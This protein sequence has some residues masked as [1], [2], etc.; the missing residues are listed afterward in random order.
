MSF[1]STLTA[2]S[3]DVLTAD[4]VATLLRVNVKLIR[5]LAMTHRLPGQRVGKAYRFSRSA[6]LQ[7]L[8][9]ENHKA[10]I[11]GRGIR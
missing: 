2:E 4:E 6:I 8:G 10:P 3:S 7:W 5:D 9:T 1:V 11:R